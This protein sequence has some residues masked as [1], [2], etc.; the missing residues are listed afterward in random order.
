[1]FT[2]ISGSNT[3]DTASTRAGWNVSVLSGSGVN[4]PSVGPAAG[5]VADSDVSEA[6][7]GASPS[8]MRRSVIGVLLRGDDFVF[9]LHGGF[10]G[11]PREA[12]AF[13]AHRVLPH[14]RENGELA[15]CIHL[16]VG[17]CGCCQH[18][19]E[20]FEERIGLSNGFA[21]ELV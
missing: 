5:V 10:H 8:G 3:F 15:Q 19:V 7:G 2:G 13:H 4:V 16:D 6:G 11:V 18:R 17:G 14:A 9:G 1:M 21:F 12:G 20:F